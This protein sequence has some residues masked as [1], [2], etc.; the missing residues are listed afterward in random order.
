MPKEIK[1]EFIPASEAPPKRKVGRPVIGAMTK[2]TLPHEIRKFV[3][4]LAHDRSE[5]RGTTLR[6]I[7]VE[8]VRLLR[9]GHFALPLPPQP[10]TVSIMEKLKRFGD[11]YITCG[12]CG[13][14]YGK[15]E[16]HVC[17]SKRKAKK[18]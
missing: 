12:R 16:E 10:E 14:D 3:S 7:V 5:R 2:V 9:E 11:M 13:A 15:D 6:L 8:A 17:K 4:D 1:D 18:K